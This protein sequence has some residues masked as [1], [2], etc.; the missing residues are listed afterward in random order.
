M[1]ESELRDELCEALRTLSRTSPGMRFGQLMASAGE[2]C[3][4]IHGRGLWEAEDG[5]L[6]EALWKLSRDLDQLAPV[7]AHEST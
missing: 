1:S 4:D 2:L 7:E 5:E 3:S 6:L